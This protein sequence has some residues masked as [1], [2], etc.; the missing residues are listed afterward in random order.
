VNSTPSVGLQ[1]GQHSR[2]GGTP[3]EHNRLANSCAH[4]WKNDAC[5]FNPAITTNKILVKYT[6]VSVVLKCKTKTSPINIGLLP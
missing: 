1:M 4:G 3:E 5:H 2:K 6:S